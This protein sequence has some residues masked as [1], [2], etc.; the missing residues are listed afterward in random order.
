MPA[1]IGAGAT[2]FNVTNTGRETHGFEIEGDGIE[3]DR[4]GP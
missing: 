1:L 2:T 4:E 3:K